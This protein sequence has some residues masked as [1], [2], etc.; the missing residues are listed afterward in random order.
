MDIGS[1]LKEMRKE[2]GLTQQQLSEKLHVSRQLISK[3][4]TSNALPDINTLL[5]LASIYHMSLQ[6]LLGEEN[7]IF[8]RKDILDDSE[9]NAILA[10]NEE[11]RKEEMFTKNAKKFM[12]LLVISLFLLLAFNLWQEWYYQ[13]QIKQMALTLYGVEDVIYENVRDLAGATYPILKTIILEDGTVLTDPTIYE[14]ES[15][16]LTKESDGKSVDVGPP[17]IID[18]FNKYPILLQQ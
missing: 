16:G 7:Q 13:K 8:D 3:W 15:L 10:T 6:E 5:L 12:T 2:H 17:M 18:Y 9:K 4:E 11:R 1:R 14:I